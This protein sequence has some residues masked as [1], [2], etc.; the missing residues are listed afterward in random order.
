MVATVLLIVLRIAR[1]LAPEVAEVIVPV[2]VRAHAPEAAQQTVA[3]VVQ[4]AVIPAVAELAQV[5]VAAGVQAVVPESVKAGVQVA[6]R[7]AVAPLVPEL[8]KDNA[9][10]A[11]GHVCKD[12]L[13]PVQTLVVA[14]AIVLVK[15]VV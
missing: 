4:V 15:V 8:V 1:L 14:L 2:H 5:D 9:A 13:Q 6:V 3:E 10:P 7:A 12:V 11:R